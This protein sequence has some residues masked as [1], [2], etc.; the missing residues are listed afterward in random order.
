M[1]KTI[2]KKFAKEEIKKIDGYS[3][4]VS[5]EDLK[6]KED[7]GRDFNGKAAEELVSEQSIPRNEITDFLVSKEVVQNSSKERIESIESFLKRIDEIISD[8]NKY[9]TNIEAVENEYVFEKCQVRDAPFYISYD[10]KLDVSITKEPEVKK[11]IKTCKGHSDSEIHTLYRIAKEKKKKLQQ[12]FAQDPFI[13][14]SEIEITDG[15]LIKD[16]KVRWE[17][18]HFDDVE[19][20]DHYELHERIIKSEVITEEDEWQNIGYNSLVESPQ[21]TFVKVE[22]LDNKSRSIDGVDANRPCWLEKMHYACR[23]DN[24]NSCG[25]LADKQCVFVSKKCV[26]QGIEGCALWELTYKCISRQ[27][28]GYKPSGQEINYHVFSETIEVEPNTSFSGIATTLSIFD[29][30]KKDLENSQAI[31]ASQVQ[32]FQGK[33]QGCAKSVLN[34]ILYDCCFSYSGLANDLKLSKCS[35]DELALADLRERGLCHYVGKHK[36]KFLNAWDSRTEHVYCC[37]P[38]KLARV[39]HE[40]ARKQL[41][42]DWG[43]SRKPNCRG[44]TS[45]EIALIDFSKIDLSEILTPPD[46]LHFE[47]YEKKPE[48]QEKL[49]CLE[50]AIK[51]RMNAMRGNP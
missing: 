12:K 49:D 11:L 34:N 22:C 47:E 36:E 46:N 25:F 28:R 50:E 26:Q 6:R 8:P 32:L 3:N 51:Q 17:W 15:N 9:V 19:L 30:L 35:S 20:C 37:F 2:G 16:Y 39:F 45:D 41:G 14:T 27:T 1:F 40:Q 38:S 44:F 43:T 18:V 13:K 21:C 7:R 10:R 48:T 33:Q 31:D 42:I 5:I 4:A 23:F 29:A 24:D